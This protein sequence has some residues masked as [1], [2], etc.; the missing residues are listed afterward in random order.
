MSYTSN[1]GGK[2]IVTAKG[3]IKTYAKEDIV[4]NSQKTINFTGKEKGTSYG[5]P[6]KIKPKT[7]LLI[8]KVEGPFDDKDQLVEKPKTGIFYT[9]KLRNIQ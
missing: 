8:T 7:D 4:L 3:S 6:K 5:E 2:L 1:I 9:Y